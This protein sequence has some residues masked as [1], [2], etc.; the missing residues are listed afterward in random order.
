VAGGL[1]SF[2]LLSVDASTFTPERSI[3]VF[4]ITVIGGLT[5]LPG[6]LLGALYVEGVPFLFGG[7]DFVRLFVSGV[8]LLALLLVVPGGLSEVAYR[9]RDR[10]LRWVAARNGIHVPSLVADSFVAAEA[11]VESGSVP[12]HGSNG[13]SD[14][15]GEVRAVAVAPFEPELVAER[16]GN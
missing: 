8:G 6:A 7:T 16:S 1:L 3:S 11:A 2:Q 4:A 14:V 13:S 9:T 10:Y 15:N 12:R 5:S